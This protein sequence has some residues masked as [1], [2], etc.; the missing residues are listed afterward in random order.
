MFLKTSNPD[1]SLPGDQLAQEYFQTHYIPSN[2]YTLIQS[3]FSLDRIQTLVEESFGQMQSICKDDLDLDTTYKNKPP[4][5]PDQFGK[6]LQVVPVDETE[7]NVIF[8]KF[9]LPR[10]NDTLD[11]ST[12]IYLLAFL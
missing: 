6:M 1:E 12:V 2:M 7:N 3:S 10:E 9:Y 4:Y 11:Y 5:S 8:I